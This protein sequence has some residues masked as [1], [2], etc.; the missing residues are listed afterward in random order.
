MNTAEITREAA[1]RHPFLVEALRAGIVNYTAAARFLDVGEV[2]VV[3]AALRRFAAELPA[4][5]PAERELR[6]RMLTGVEKVPRADGAILSV[7]ERG[8]GVGRGEHSAI[9]IEGPIDST[10]VAGVWGQLA[11]AGVE[12]VAAAHDHDR[13]V[14][15]VSKNDGPRVIQLIE[16]ANAS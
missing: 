3:A 16:E 6:I 8:F 12:V 13:L 1:T 2:D 11:V 7:D 9:Q 10:F 15:V 4:T 14:I 5:E